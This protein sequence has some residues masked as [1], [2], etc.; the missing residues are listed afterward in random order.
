M[1]DKNLLDDNSL[2]SLEELTTEANNIIEVLEKEKDLESSIEDYKK[3]IRLNNIIEQKFKKNSK[4][5]NEKTNQKIK[6]IVKKKN[7]K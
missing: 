4:Q 7:E 6:E 2:L 1:N 5:I 3:L